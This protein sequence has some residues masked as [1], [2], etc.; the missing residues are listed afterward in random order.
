LRAKGAAFKTTRLTDEFGFAA[1]N[2]RYADRAV[3]LFL[4]KKNGE[5]QV[6]TP[7]AVRKPA[8]GDAILSLLSPAAEDAPLPILSAKES[9]APTARDPDAIAGESGNREDVP[10][11]SNT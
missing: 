10:G 6:Y 2:A 9:A 11:S 7:D 5:L 4:L 8:P 1:W 3:P